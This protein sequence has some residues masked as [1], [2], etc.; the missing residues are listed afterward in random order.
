M[1]NIIWTSQIGQ[2]KF[3]IDALSGKNNGFFVDLG[4]GPPRYIS[5]TYVLEKYFNWTGIA[6]DIKHSSLDPN[7][8][9]NFEE[10]R[11]NTNYVISD[12]LTVNYS[13]LFKKYNAPQVIDYLSIDLE[14]PSITLECLF[15]IP[16]D[17]YRFNTITF[18]VDSYR[19][20]PLDGSTGIERINKSRTFLQEKGY[21]FLFNRSNCDDFYIHQDIF[22]NLKRKNN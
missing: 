5:N 10:Y 4:A 2:D 13:E 22:D 6:V 12:C 18:E 7:S 8:K 1:D 15:K 19:D 17:E 11:P 20:C 3:V 21:V 14:P 16:F 9:E